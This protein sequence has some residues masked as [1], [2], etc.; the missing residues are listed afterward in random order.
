MDDSARTSVDLLVRRTWNVTDGQGNS[1]GIIDVN[2]DDTD[3][4]ILLGIRVGATGERFGRIL[5]L[6]DRIET[7][8]LDLTVTELVSEE[9][10]KLVLRGTVPTREGGS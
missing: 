1:F 4:A 10:V 5:R 2:P 3:P 8:G 9:P 6:G 7:D